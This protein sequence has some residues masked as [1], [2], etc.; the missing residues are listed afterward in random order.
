MHSSH[1]RPPG[2]RAGLAHGLLPQRPAV[3]AG[4]TAIPAGLLMLDPAPFDWL[5][6]LT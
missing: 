4:G 1:V 6:Q 3:G 5:E 2:A